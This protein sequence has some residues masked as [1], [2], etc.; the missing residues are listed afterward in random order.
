MS[1][2]ERHFYY[3]R[4]LRALL[5]LSTGYVLSM[6]NASAQKARPSLLYSLSAIG[7]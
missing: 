1:P 4:L 5:V 7:R 2:H 6:A 3:R